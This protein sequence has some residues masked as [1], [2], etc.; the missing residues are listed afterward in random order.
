MLA[1]QG[2]KGIGNHIRKKQI[3]KSINDMTENIF[4]YVNSKETDTMN[5]DNTTAQ[6]D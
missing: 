3:R 4:D 6:K 2:V 1:A 5:L